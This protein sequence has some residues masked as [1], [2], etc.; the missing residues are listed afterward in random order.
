MACG[1]RLM[2]IRIAQTL[3]FPVQAYHSLNILMEKSAPCISAY[4]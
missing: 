2:D 4:P 1:T 3:P